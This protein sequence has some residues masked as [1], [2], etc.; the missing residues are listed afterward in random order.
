MQSV[1]YSRW[2]T[3][4]A[5][6]LFF[7]A[8]AM[9]ALEASKVD[10]KQARWVSLAPSLTEVIFA[11][12]AEGRLV[13]R[14]NYCNYPEEALAVPSVGRMDLPNLEAIVALKPDLVVM[15]DLTPLDTMTRL[16]GLGLEVLRLRADR[17]EDI[18]E[19]YRRLGGR[20]GLE[21]EAERIVSEIYG[22]LAG[23]TAKDSA[24][25]GEAPRACLLYGVTAPFFSAGEGTFP[26]ALLERAGFTN[27]ADAA[28]LAWPQLNLEWL[29]Q[30]NPEVIFVAGGSDVGSAAAV[31]A[32]WQSSEV[33]RQVTAIQRNQVYCIRDD[34][35]SVPGMRTL[36][37]L[38][39]I[40]AARAKFP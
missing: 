6:L 1:R 23:L 17:L 3:L 30:Q 32:H 24:H 33:W 12:N 10:A 2:T 40:S 9:G 15:T 29:I 37:A 34:A 26:S 38:R 21:A 22:A 31:L 11:L 16:E 18:A 7:N 8:T 13:G 4:W 20:L 14:S 35:L 19:T 39:V 36:E 27:I 25:G 28:P 5:A